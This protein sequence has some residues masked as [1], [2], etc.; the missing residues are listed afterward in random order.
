MFCGGLGSASVLLFSEISPFFPSRIIIRSSSIALE[1]CFGLS[2]HRPQGDGKNIYHAALQPNHRI[3]VMNKMSEAAKQ[4]PKKPLTQFTLARF[5][6]NPEQLTDA[7]R[8][9]VAP[10][11]KRKPGRP[12]K[13]SNQDGEGAGT[14]CAWE[15]W[16]PAG[17]TV[18]ATAAGSTLEATAAGSTLAATASGSTLA[19][20][21]AGGTLA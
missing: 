14:G 21:A 17:S 12:R 10:P 5:V 2:L 13:D 3:L 1:N 18:E 9:P 19:A 20:T 8:Q 7:D 11:A 6:K 4:A 16:E 15:A